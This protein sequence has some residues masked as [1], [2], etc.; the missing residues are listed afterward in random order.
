[1][2]KPTPAEIQEMLISTTFQSEAFIV[3]VGKKTPYMLDVEAKKQMDAAQARQAAGLPATTP[4]AFPNPDS[5]NPQVAEKLAGV[6][7]Y[8]AKGDVV[9]LTKAKVGFKA[10]FAGVVDAKGV[11]VIDPIAD[12][13]FD[14]AA[15][16][17]VEYDTLRKLGMNRFGDPQGVDTLGKW[18]KS[19]TYGSC[20]PNGGLAD[21]YVALVTL[22]QLDQELV[23]GKLEWNEMDC[24]ITINRV[25]V[26]DA[27]TT[28]DIRVAIG[29]TYSV[30]TGGKRGNR[31][32]VPAEANVQQAIEAIAR[33]NK[34]HPAREYFEQLPTWH[35]SDMMLPLLKAIGGWRDT[36]GLFGP[37]LEWTDKVNALALS[38]LTK[39]LIGTVARTFVPGCQMDTMLVLKSKQGTRKSSLFRALAPAG[40]F[41][42]T[43]IEFGSKDS[44][45]TFMQNTWIEIAELSAMQR[46]DVQ[47]VKAEVT[48]RSDDIRLPYGRA[49]TKNPRWC[50]LVGST[51]DDTFLKDQTGSRRFWIIVV[52]DD[53]KTDIS[54]IESIKDQIWAQALHIYRSS[55]VCPDCKA[56]TDGEVR[57]AAHRWWLGADEEKFREKFNEQFTEQEPYVEP[58]KAWLKN[59]ISDKKVAKQ[60]MHAAYKNTDAL[61]IH[62]LLEAVAGLTGK[63]CHDML[64]QKRMAHALK[65]CG[66][67]K[68]HTEDGSLWISPGMQGRPELVVVPPPLKAEPDKKLEEA[69][70]TVDPLKTVK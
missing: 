69:L 16:E 66:Y 12:Q 10:H 54:Y 61:R 35:G 62:E 65:V 39:F 31:R 44:R 51:N 20:M 57:C 25:R 70:E 13:L 7:K 56:A 3:S 43:H 63:D 8:F 30:A 34:Y 21:D 47:L 58:L 6:L 24:C 1:M 4:K 22:L 2:P 68:R 59:A 67:I 49:M 32:F 64:Q 11:L 38:Q 48:E 29:S 23:G 45:M 36:T 37:S 19:Q 18:V 14:G 17:D 42:S 52:D 5:A 15:A 60:G 40:R 55:A 46:K 28:S 50:V 26:E 41:S 53:K 33:K 9:L 27:K